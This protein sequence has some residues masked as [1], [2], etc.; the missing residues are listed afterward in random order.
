MIVVRTKHTT[1]EFG[2]GLVVSQH[3]F[4]MNKSVTTLT[5]IVKTNE[6][7]TRKR[8]DHLTDVVENMTDR[9]QKIGLKML[10]LIRKPTSK[11]NRLLDRQAPGR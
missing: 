2:F 5:H 9:F 6:E 8:D 7:E 10:S 3:L 4:G 11:E 1:N